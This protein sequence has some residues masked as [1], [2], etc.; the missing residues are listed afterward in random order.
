MLNL[1]LLARKKRK[2]KD[3]SYGYC[4]YASDGSDE[5]RC[6]G[7]EKRNLMW[8]PLTGIAERRRNTV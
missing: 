7:H 6:K 4:E 3:E 8:R 2:T 1:E 5:G